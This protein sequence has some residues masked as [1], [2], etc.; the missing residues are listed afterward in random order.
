ML[1]SSIRHP[2]HQECSSV[3]AMMTLILAGQDT[4]ES[5]CAQLT[6]RFFRR[7]VLCEASY[8]HYL[9]PDKRDMSVTGRLCH[10]KTFELPPA[11]TKNLKILSS[12]IACD[13]A[14]SLGPVLYCAIDVFCQYEDHLDACRAEFERWQHWCRRLEPES[15]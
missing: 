11:R 6:E 9:L 10:A 1:A 8:L 3:S 7:S 5:R 2:P 13:I 12:P 4:L 14:I 15:E